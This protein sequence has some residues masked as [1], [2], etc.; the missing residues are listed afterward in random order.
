VNDAP[1]FRDGVVPRVSITDLFVLYAFIEPDPD[2]C[3]PLTC[4]YRDKYFQMSQL[5]IGAPTESWPPGWD[6]RRSGMCM[7][8]C[9]R[10]HIFL[11]TVHMVVDT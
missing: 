11:Y 2:I 1:L 6:K 3:M 5:L 7:S 10:L 9:L 8:V 4:L